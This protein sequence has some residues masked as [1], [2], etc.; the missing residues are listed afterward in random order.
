MP[1][2]PSSQQTQTTQ[3]SGSRVR[4]S[5]TSE[6]FGGAQARALTGLGSSLQNRA[7]EIKK[8][9]DSN[10][11]KEAFTKASDELREYLHG[12][13]GVYNKQG[14][15]SF[16]SVQATN[17]K[18]EEISSRVGELLQNE[19]QKA[20]FGTLWGQRRETSL[21]GVSR[22]ESGQRKVYTEQATAALIKDS[23][24]NAINNYT[25]DEA[26]A[27]SL[28]TAELA[29]RTSGEG[30]ELGVMQDQIA[31]AHSNIHKAVIQRRMI[32]D[33]ASAQEYYDSNKDNIDGQDHITIEKALKTRTLNAEAQSKT[34]EIM[35]SNLSPSDQM[36]AARAEDNAELRDNIVSRVKSRQAQEETIKNRENK[37][38]S[39]TLWKE[40]ELSMESGAPIDQLEQIRDL[41]PTR[42]VRAAMDKVIKDA[43][44]GRDID[45][46]WE[47]YYELREMSWT[48]PAAF[49]N[50]NLIEEYGSLATAE[51]EKLID[52][53]QSIGGDGDSA[54]RSLNQM[55][56]T[57]MSSAKILKD[58]DSTE[59]AN[60]KKALV[61]RQVE[62]DLSE[63]KFL[64]G[65][66]AN[67]EDTLKIIDQN[68][69]NI[70]IEG[71]GFF[72]TSL[73]QTEFKAFQ[74]KSGTAEIDFD[75]IP[76]KDVEEI[77][78]SRRKV[79]LPVT[80]EAIINN[81][82]QGLLSNA[83]K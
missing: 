10:A 48:D 56:T 33:P 30:K 38:D 17:E 27:D 74:L 9:D 61:W 79:G 20:M 81:Y 75:D 6:D 11:S 71:S 58:S 28:D 40:L 68:L 18:M 46:D 29:I 5:A 32:S 1:T 76:K 69:E 57:E 21:N 43:A 59:E 80:K 51:R 72:G 16:G 2:V 83:G 60:A 77:T 35:A 70:V 14:R 82:S 63:F 37:K 78:Q 44:S 67:R 39:E 47:R 8:Q 65:R 23:E 73:G 19:D 13:N 25:D 24:D 34:D 26:I 50:K 22:Y 66:D 36:K 41:G 15:N 7:L 64:N 4:A 42:A 53:Q 49:K 54:G 3:V 45:T 62:K 31:S 12:E 52:I 55:I